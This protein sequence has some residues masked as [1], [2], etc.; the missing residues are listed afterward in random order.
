MAKSFTFTEARQKLASVLKIA[1]REGEVRITH[2][3]GQVYVIRP[4][5]TGRSPLDVGGVDTG[6]TAEEINEIVREGRERER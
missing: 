2:K 4:E 3:S 1:S 6:I 5:K